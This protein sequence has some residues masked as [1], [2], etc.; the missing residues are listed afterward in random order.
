[1]GSIFA[2]PGECHPPS[3]ALAK[4]EVT[5]AGDWKSADEISQDI[6]VG[7]VSSL[8]RLLVD[9]WRREDELQQRVRELESGQQHDEK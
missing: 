2:P 4:G 6:E 1:L 9:L 8:E 5:M 3:Q 7:N